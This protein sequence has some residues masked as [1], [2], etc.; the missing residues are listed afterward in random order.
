MSH[1]T[2][3]IQKNQLKTNIEAAL[4]WFSKFNISVTAVTKGVSAHPEIVSFLYENKI[5]SFADS[6]LQNLSAIK[7][8]LPQCQLTYL[9]IPLP[10]MARQICE[11]A[12]Q[13]MHSSLDTIEAF[14]EAS[15]NLKKTHKI[16]LMIET[17]DLRE[18]VLPENIHPLVNRVLNSSVLKLHGLATN[19]ACFGGIRPDV[20]NIQMFCDLTREIQS[21]Y[22]ISIPLVSGGSTS[23]LDYFSSPQSNPFTINS[24]RIGVGLYL[25][26]E[27]PDFSFL[28]GATDNAVLVSIPVLESAMKPSIPYGGKTGKNGFG[29]IPQFE[30]HGVCSRV[31]LGAGQQDLGIGSLIPVSHP[32]KLIGRTSDYIVAIDPT[33][34][35]K[36]GDS[37]L[38]KPDYEAMMHLF[39]SPY[40]EL[41]FTSF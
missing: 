17:G 26:R 23:C 2:L 38:F 19:L 3:I 25:G 24:I 34:S 11:V 8:I 14:E 28:P 7:D 31:L 20:K 37:I 12:T 5:Q 36:P 27:H 16:I 32:L 41:S 21:R 18:G 40:T 30:D 6:R 39:S 1:P 22:K 29:Q 10:S 4:N 9:R 13:S 33:G 35:L 15:R